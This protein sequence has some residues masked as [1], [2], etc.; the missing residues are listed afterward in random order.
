MRAA[1]H[2]RLGQ[3][4]ESRG[5]AVSP[6]AAVNE[7]DDRR[8]RRA[9][10]IEIERLDPASRRSCVAW[11]EA[12]PSPRPPPPSGARPSAPGWAPRRSG[13]RQRPARPGP[14]RATRAA[15]SR[16]RLQRASS[17]SSR[18]VFRARW[19][20]VSRR[21]ARRL[22]AAQEPRAGAQRACA[23]PAFA[24]GASRRERG[25]QQEIEP[26]DAEPRARGCRWPHRS[27]WRGAGWRPAGRRDLRRRGWRRST[28]LSASLLSCARQTPDQS[29]F[30]TRLCN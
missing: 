16:A 12:A 18:I 30:Y 27:P 7:D 11:A 2:E 28:S 13:R 4:R 15:P 21:R 17:H 14:C 24:R 23:R 9:A 29:T 26:G 25:A 5:H 8:G 19:N 10:G 20:R 6:C 22:E 1:G 3:M